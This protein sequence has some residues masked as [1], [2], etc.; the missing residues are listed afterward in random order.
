MHLR[1]LKIT[2]EKFCYI[3]CLRKHTCQFEGRK[4]LLKSKMDFK[5]SFTS[6]F[7]LSLI[8]SMFSTHLILSSPV[9]EFEFPKSGISFSSSDE[10]DEYKDIARCL[11]EEDYS[12]PFFDRN[13]GQVFELKC[14]SLN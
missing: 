7:G 6:C 9:P 14:L 8:I 1:G 4:V 13:T 5:I 12:M 10:N 3:F 2:E 11:N